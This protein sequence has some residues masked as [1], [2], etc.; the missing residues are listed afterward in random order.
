MLLWK[1]ICMSVQKYLTSCTR[2]DQFVCV[3][4][5]VTA[6]MDMYP[7]TFR[8]KNRR[9]LFILVVALLSFLMGL[10]MLTEVCLKRA[11]VTSYYSYR[12]C[13]VFHHHAQQ[14]GLLPF[15]LCFWSNVSA[16]REACTSSSSSTTTQPAAC[17]CSSWQ[18]SRLC[19]SL[20]FTVSVWGQIS[21]RI[22]VLFLVILN[23]G[24]RL[25]RMCFPYSSPTAGADRFYDNI[26]DM[27][28]YRPSPVIKYCWLYFTPATCFV[29]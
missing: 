22:I 16:C 14:T 29:G 4:S 23:V 15:T 13:H 27:I 20:G 10:I 9:E 26:E 1:K 17:V 25:K 7:A 12:M 8:R 19:V 18:F 24:Y 28:G 3:E 21:R 5:L 6:M 2:F 11:H